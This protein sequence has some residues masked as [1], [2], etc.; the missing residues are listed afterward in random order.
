MKCTH[1]DS[2]KV[3]DKTFITDEQDEDYDDPSSFLISWD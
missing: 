3:S 2:S 1:Q